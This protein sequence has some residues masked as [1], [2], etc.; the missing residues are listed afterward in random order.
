MQYCAYKENLWYGGYGQQIK[1]IE[2]SGY[3]YLSIIQDS[4]IITQVMTD[5]I[6]T[7]YW[8]RVRKLPKSKSYARN[9]FMW[10]SGIIG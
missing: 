4:E 5:K 6:R 7:E 2:K 10:R 8:E 9:M 1:Q 3:K